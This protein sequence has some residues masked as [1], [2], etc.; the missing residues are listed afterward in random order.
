MQEKLDR[1]NRV[2]REGLT[3]IR[4]IRAFDRIDYEK[5]RFNEAN[6]DLTSTAIRVNKIMATAMPLMMVAMNFMAIASYGLAVSV[7]TKAACRWAP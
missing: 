6:L 3:G 7:L 5:Q 4:V 2:L 1:V